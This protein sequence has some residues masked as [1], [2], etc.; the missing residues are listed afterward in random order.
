MSFGPLRTDRLIVRR[1]E[2]GDADALHQRRNHPD[3]ARYQDWPLPFSMESARR[4]TAGTATM[5]GPADD[6]WWMM[7]IAEAGTDSI[8]GDVAI[9]QSFQ[10][11]AAEIGY[12]L[13]PDHWGKGYGTEAVSAVVDALIDAGIRRLSAST[14]PDN[15][16]SVRLLERLGFEYEGRE[17]QS[18]FEADGPE[19]EATDGLLFG[20]TATSRARWLGRPTTR[21]S[22]VRLLEIG[23]HNHREVA[24][25]ATHHSQ[26]HL[27]AP[28]LESFGDALFPPVV[29]GRP[30]QPWLRAIEI[31]QA[32][33]PSP[34][35]AGFIM[36]ALPT[37]PATADGARSPYLWRL[38]IDRWH[39][40]RGIASL[41][42]DQIE[43]M[44]RADGH[45]SVLVHWEPGPGSPEP[46]YL[47]R[48]YRPTGQ[49]AGTEIEGRKQLA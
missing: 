45:R 35:L 46:F 12:T 23:G 28:V 49:M 13:H 41:A 40:R 16:D 20:M 36:M 44:L 42:L 3:A 43:D 1:P 25:L 4:A 29:D 7:T 39:Q 33:Q 22:A 47:A 6:E 27:V 26:Q 11:R 17:V 30:V 8:V 10:G 31:D 15:V 18:Y 5:D 34:T 24:R 2:I 19:A 21:P 37:E 9:H 32:E 38:L 14:H 48:D